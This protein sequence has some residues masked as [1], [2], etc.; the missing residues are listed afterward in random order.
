MAP[1][2][3]SCQFQDLP[4]SISFSGSGFMATYQLGVAQCLLNHAP[5]LLRTAPF[6]LGASAGS[7][8]A[9]AVVCDMSLTQV[10]DEMLYFA[11]HMKA[12]TLGPLNPSINVFHWLEGILRKHL[13]SDAHKLANGR[14]V[15]AMTRMTDGKHAVM[16]EFQSKDEVVQAL[17]CSCFVPGYCGMQPPSFKGVHYVDGG[18]TSMQP[19]MTAPSSHTLT[20]CPFSGEIDICPRDTASKWDMVVSGTALKA[21]MANSFRIINALYPMALETLE[22][23]YHSGYKDAIHFLQNSDLA[24]H[25]M[26]QKASPGPQN[27]YLNKKWM[28]LETT[29]EEDEEE[30]IKEEEESAAL[31]AST[32]S[33]RL[34][35]RDSTEDKSALKM[36]E[37]AATEPAPHADM[38]QNVLLCNLL[39]YLSMFGFPMT[40]LS[41]LLLPLTMPLFYILQ[42]RHR[43]QL[44]SAETPVLLFWLWHSLRQF[45][46]FFT[47]IVIC[48]IKKNVTERIMPAILLL[49]W[50][51]VQAEF[52]GPGE[53]SQGRWYSTL[54]PLFSSAFHSPSSH[55][56]SSDEPNK[57]NLLSHLDHEEDVSGRGSAH[58]RF[59]RYDSIMG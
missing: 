59:P 24:F 27:Y 44:W 39:S 58:R 51:N 47:T 9:A 2:V 45:T 54:H 25:L 55:S 57:S 5:W 18:F 20:I 38:I 17:L 23:A 30:E 29:L 28:E 7:L 52:E 12:F 42:N 8:V 15:V 19:I 56:L 3:S 35:T 36:N 37:R 31:T 4:P 53:K 11:K 50:L 46:V 13:P 33:R 32:D 41:Y 26:M 21:N 6:V 1:G 48:T 49:Q 43:L 10:R 14:L 34:Q 22:Q 40:V 16:S